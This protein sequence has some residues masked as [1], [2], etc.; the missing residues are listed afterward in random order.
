[1]LGV[2]VAGATDTSISARR[3]YRSRSGDSRVSTLLLI[4]LSPFTLVVGRSAVVVL[5][6]LLLTTAR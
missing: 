6:L 2:G 3:D 1:M 5:L 4:I